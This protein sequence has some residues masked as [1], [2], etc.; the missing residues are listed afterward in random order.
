M[1]GDLLHGLV[2]RIDDVK[3]CLTLQVGGICVLLV[4]INTLLDELICIELRL[5]L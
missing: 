2:L 3:L 1:F 5:A 4:A